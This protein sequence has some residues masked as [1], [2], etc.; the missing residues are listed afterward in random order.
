MYVSKLLTVILISILFVGC[1]GSDSPP[2]GDAEDSTN[3]PELP[4]IADETPTEAVTQEVESAIDSTS[5]NVDD[6]ADVPPLEPKEIEPAKLKEVIE[7]IVGGASEAA[8]KL[9]EETA[10]LK[11]QGKTT[12]PP[13]VP[14][15]P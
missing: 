4:S 3:P 6:A 8:D 13:K 1:G 5:T 9:F 2:T 10:A 12:N 7:E 11:D 15:L 14:K